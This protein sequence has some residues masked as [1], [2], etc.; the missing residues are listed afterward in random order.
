MFDILYWVLRIGLI[1][2]KLNLLLSSVQ[3]AFIK[4]NT[5]FILALC[6]EREKCVCERLTPTHFTG[7]IQVP[8]TADRRQDCDLF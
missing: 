7:V 3:W 1:Y 5:L 2:A 8:D 6:P 4:E